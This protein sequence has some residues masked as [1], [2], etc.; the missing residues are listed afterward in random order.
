MEPASPKRFVVALLAAIMCLSIGIALAEIW[1]HPNFI[2][3]MSICFVLASGIY[4]AIYF[5]AEQW[6]LQK[7][8]VLFLNIFFKT[9]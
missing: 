3:F 4:T 8:K 5:K 6:A 2:L 9:Y 7:I 1:F